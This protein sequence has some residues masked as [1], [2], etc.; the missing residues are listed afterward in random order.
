ME[1]KYLHLFDTE[2]N[3]SI[4]AES[5]EYHVPYVSYTIESYKVR[6]NLESK[7]YFTIIPQTSGTIKFKT[8]NAS[9]VKTIE[10]SYDTI[11]WTQISSSV[12][13][14]NIPVT[15]SKKLY[16]RGYNSSYSNGTDVAKFDF[17]GINVKLAGNIMSLINYET[18]DSEY[19]LS[20]PNTFKNFFSNCSEITNVSNLYLLT[21]ELP[22]SAYESM[23]ENC[24]VLTSTPI[25]FAN[26]FGVNACKKM[27]KGCTS[28]V[29]IDVTIYDSIKQRYAD[30]S[31]T[32]NISYTVTTKGSYGFTLSNG[33]YESQNKAYDNSAAVCRVNFNLASQMAIT[34]EFICYGESSCDYGLFGK[35]DTALATS[36]SSD[37]T[38][39]LQLSCNSTTYNDG[40]VHTLTYTIPAGQ[41]FVDIKYRKDVSVSKFS[42]SLKWKILGA[43]NTGLDESEIE[44][45]IF[46]SGACEEM[47]MNCTSLEQVNNFS[48][49]KVYSNSLK[50]MFY[51]CFK[52][53]K[54][55]IYLNGLTLDT[56]CYEEMFC[57]CTKLTKVPELYSTK[58]AQNCYKRM[59]AE[60]NITEFMLPST[61]LVAG[62][63]E[64]MFKDCSSFYELEANFLSEPSITYT[65]DWLTNVKE[66]G[67]FI[68]NPDAEW[69][70]A[71]YLNENGINYGIPVHWVENAFSHTTL[72]FTP[73]TFKFLGNG[74]W[75]IAKSESSFTDAGINA[76]YRKNNGTWIH[77]IPNTQ[78]SVVTGDTIEVKSSSWNS[79]SYNY[80]CFNSTVDYE[81]YGNIMSLTRPDDFGSSKTIQ[82]DYNFRS[83]F[84][85]QHKLKSIN[86]LVLPA[87]SLKTSCYSSM[88]SGCIGLTTIPSNLL[89]ANTLASSCYT[90][91]FSNCIGLE[92]I[93]SSL[94]HAKN[95]AS[96]CYSGMFSGCT[97]LETIPENLLP[98]TTLADYCYSSMFSNCTNINY[99]SPN[100]LKST[101][102]ANYCY[103]SMFSNTG[104][105]ELNEKIFASVIKSNSCNNMF[106]GCKS[107]TTVGPNFLHH[108]ETIY[109]S[110]LS[111]IF[112]D[113]SNL[114][115]VPNKLF[116]DTIEF[117][118]ESSSQCYQMFAYSGIEEIT[119]T[120]LNVQTLTSNCYESM[121]EGCKSLIT[122]PNNLLN[123]AI[124]A[125]NCCASMF[126]N[127]DNLITLPENLLPQQDLADGCY[128]HMFNACDK[129][130][131]TCNL[132]ATELSNNCYEYMFAECPSLVTV[133]QI[134]AENI[135]DNSCQY[136]FRNCTSLYTVAN[137]KF[138]K[139]GQSGCSH[140]FDNCDTL[141]EIT[142]DNI[143]TMNGN[144]ACYYMFTECN[145][146]R[147]VNITIKKCEYQS[148]C[149]YMFNY[150]SNLLDGITIETDNVG[151][152]SCYQMFYRCSNLT[153]IS[154][155][156]GSGEPNV[157]SQVDTSGCY[158]MFYECTNLNCS[159]NLNM[160]IIKDNGC[161]QMF[162]NCTSFN[163]ITGL[164][165]LAVNYRACYYM[166]SG[167]SSLVECSTLPIENINGSEA[168]YY[169]F[170]ACTSLRVVPS[171]LP[172]RMLKDSCYRS[173]YRGC[174][175]LSQTPKLPALE[176]ATYCYY[177]MFES[178]TSLTEVQEISARILASYCCGYM[179]SSCSSLLSAP[180][181]YARNLVEH[182]YNYM[183]Q[184][185]S[186][187][188]YICAMFITTPSNTY[189]NYWVS[190]VATYG[191]FIQGKGATWTNR[192]TNAIP[193]NWNIMSME[194]STILV[195]RD[196]I[197]HS[198]TAFTD[199]LK[200]TSTKNYTITKDNWININSLSG[201]SGVTTFTI[202][203]DSTNQT[204]TGMISISDGTEQFDVIIKQILSSSVANDE[205]TFYIESS[206]S[207]IFKCQTTSLSYH[208]EIQYK[209]ND[210]EWTTVKVPS[211]SYDTKITDT[212]GGDIIK[213]RGNNTQY[214]TSVDYYY[215]YFAASCKFVLGGNIMSLIDGT[216]FNSITQ[217]SSQF[218]FARLFYGCTTL[219][220]TELLNMPATILTKSCYAY[221]FQNCSG[222]K[223]ISTKPIV[224]SSCADYS[225]DSV[226]YGC[227]ALINHPSSITINGNTGTYCFSQMFYNCK[228]LTSMPT[229][230][231]NGNPGTYCFYSMFY[232]CSSLTATSPI[233]I[234]CTSCGDHTFMRMF[235]TCRNLVTLNTVKT[236]ILSNNC[237]EQMYIN[238]SSLKTVQLPVKLDGSIHDILS[239]SCYLN[240]FN[241]SGIETVPQLGN[242][243]LTANC[244][245]GMFKDCKSLT[246]INHTFANIQLANN[247]YR[248]MF[249]GC[250]SLQSM[251][252][253]QSQSLANGCYYG[254]F[255]GCTSLVVLM[256]S[257]P[258]ITL[259]D[260]CYHH[261]FYECSS[262][263]RCPALP[264]TELK[265]SCYQNMFEGCTSLVDSGLPVLSATALANSCYYCMFEGCTKITITPSINVQSTSIS[266]MQ[267]M[268]AACTK[269]TNASGISINAT[270]SSMCVEMFIDCTALTNAPYINVS[271]LTGTNIFQNMFN[272]C[273]SLVTAQQTLLPTVLTNN[274]YDSMFKGCTSLTTAPE[275]KATS[276]G[277]NSCK[278][279]FEG[280]TSLVNIQE[281][282]YSLTLAD[283]CYIRMFYGCNKITTAPILP[284]TQLVAH[285][286]EEMFYNCS[287]LNRI[288][289]NFL[290]APGTTYTSNWVYGVAASGFFEGNEMKSW[291]NVGPN[292]IPVGWQTN[293]FEVF[294]LD[295][296]IHRCKTNLS[297][298]GFSYNST[299]TITSDVNW[300]TFLTNTDITINNANFTTNIVVAASS[301]F[302]R[303]GHVIFR[304]IYTSKTYTT[305]IVQTDGDP[306]AIYPGEIDLNNQW[307]SAGTMT[308]TIDGVLKTVTY[309]KSNSNYHV[310]SGM[311]YCYLRFRGLTNI[312]LQVRTYGQNYYD[313]LVVSNLDK[314]PYLYSSTNTDIKWS[315][316]SSSSQTTWYPIEFSNISSG[317]HTITL[318]YG[319]NGSTNSNDDRAYFYIE[320]TSYKYVD[321]SPNAIIDNIT[322]N[323]NQYINLGIINQNGL[324]NNDCFGQIDI[325]LKNTTG[326]GFTTST[327]IVTNVTRNISFGISST[328]Y[329]AYNN[330]TALTGTTTCND[331]L[332]NNET[333]ENALFRIKQKEEGNSSILFRPSNS[334]TARYYEWPVGEQPFD[335]STDSFNLNWCNSVPIVKVVIYPPFGNPIELVPRN[336]SDG[337]HILYD[338]T[339]DVEYQIQ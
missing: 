251:P 45:H 182:C 323:T 309:Y 318:L 154:L 245:Q 71:E 214:T 311:A 67:V 37:S 149:A 262:I 291:Q 226:Y 198:E 4:H 16:I 75:K 282:L 103:N 339:N 10:Y 301:D 157:N 333:S 29:N 240:M 317:Q 46:N 210:G 34:F 217:F 235:D 303:T 119:S 252:Q 255:Q 191:T 329:M 236:A 114:K 170:N 284:A 332:E 283:S 308:A 221:M 319:K 307:V 65:K 325:F 38:S 231:I 209:L 215:N 315:G 320:S 42:D 259:A 312:K 143:V 244:Y 184:S 84:I 132:P 297:I 238:C 292:G 95:L 53:V 295:F 48:V 331:Y 300:I 86:N 69:E 117:D 62:C 243:T 200:V 164:K 63:Y 219:E 92:S 207:L 5:E 134:L 280:C 121:F 246:T 189:T 286:Y 205:L 137:L 241:E 102:L 171:E 59:F 338:A 289:A 77:I 51:N 82:Y 263:T 288:S 324:L 322:L 224:I 212:V 81:V 139:I 31:N 185:C 22:E 111:G 193:T 218:A 80:Y 66:Y 290:T 305:T 104:V 87:T 40:N 299:I 58:L 257:L 153:N 49:N 109:S 118:S 302:T 125:S 129:L 85:N 273:T 20:S 310:N 202:S 120:F 192:G 141:E 239:T 52:L 136:M 179:F 106:S 138:K 278:S 94:L 294:D 33:Y 13:G 35:V 227:S 334:T 229:I 211:G 275:I 7:L 183:F 172:C 30:T 176:L 196:V 272:G 228:S 225:I 99:I 285:C 150:C 264:S 6:Y 112:R 43:E 144:N 1:S 326:T 133:K 276:L 169:M 261:M 130:F 61:T 304:D 115:N 181:L 54:A 197:V 248:E 36:N 253:L 281:E 223:T 91:M 178:C 269:L 242:V 70:V 168:C 201:E 173:M 230:T 41:H 123:G 293:I 97:K 336:D 113:C 44:Y 249:M 177:G 151:V 116:S 8:T 158:Q 254:M 135:G 3:F 271:T 88:F 72:L 258:A 78:I 330:S 76:Y 204:R 260:N 160:T 47:F 90:S 128:G 270:N 222:L 56:S 175:A 105:T 74:N 100:L 50:R 147:T 267:R 60:T 277:T 146:L 306:D 216:D 321:Y 15:T 2:N 21:T 237:C 55:N 26:I 9:Y 73:L 314:T 68:K 220:S 296:E 279:M 79:G 83:L 206:G 28:L 188:N 96:S 57:K 107:L 161:Y 126:K 64:E 199:K 145:L 127:C 337:Y 110:G 232:G 233:T 131:E 140:M 313:Y 142:F 148:C 156:I 159:M 266:S 208:K 18:F 32:N 89:P 268:F 195:D 298:N 17:N 327:P 19:A 328:S 152:N 108:I 194:D 124:L 101:E 250:I 162:T 39:L 93:P 12:A 234:D 247:C 27:F 174:S 24:T 23:F 256:T 335:F 11:N 287:L 98:A 25:M 163:G 186:K 166:F 203:A 190:G 274:C 213:V 180:I 316:Y 122:L 187:L 265:T 14:V 167:C 155:T 165:I